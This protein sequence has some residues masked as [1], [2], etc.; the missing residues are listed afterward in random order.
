MAPKFRGDGDDWLDDDSNQSK[1]RAKPK[2]AQEAR[3]VALPPEE[4]TATVSEVFPNLCKVR[5][6]DDGSEILCSYRRANVI[7]KSKMDW[8]ERS[9]VAVGDRVRA[10]KSSPD[11]GVVDGICARK[12]SLSRPAPGRE[13]K[14]FLHVIAA[15]VDGLVIVAAAHEPEFS[16]GLVDR[17]LV[18]AEAAGIETRICVTKTDLL[19]PSDS[20]PW[21]K[22]WDV[23][24]E[25]GYPVHE[26]SVRSAGGIA[27]LKE[28]LL[29]RT[30]VFCGHSGVG[31]TSL[32]RVLL[33]S[34]VGKVGQ[35]SEATGKGRH[36][37]TGA[38][39][40]G[41]PGS[42]RWIDTPGVREFGLVDVTP[43]TLASWFK[44]FRDLRCTKEGCH[45]I[46]QAGCDAV[47]LP[48]YASYRRIWLSLTEGEH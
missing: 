17:Y 5:M 42:S 37:T 15:N 46:D 35:V 10:I 44:E 6:D 16:P 21:P 30:I 32:L 28:H 8:R 39:L 23:Y 19:K 48:R 47:G 41:G 3:S 13:G 36:T 11:S 24:R 45:H 9:P 4:A 29:G 22:P 33:A 7:S 25:I 1:R 2:K 26:V 38:V 20:K 34:D 43:E 40:L 31:K 27:E 14:T 18:A 12:N